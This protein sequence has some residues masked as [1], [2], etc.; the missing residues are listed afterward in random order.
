MSTTLHT[1]MDIFKEE[2]ESDGKW[3]QVQKIIIPI[4][5]RDYA[6][7][8]RT[9]K[10]DRIRSRFLDSLYDAVTKEAVILDFVYGSIDDNGVM[11]PLDGQQRLTTLFLLHWYAAVKENVAQQEYSFLKNFSYETSYSARTFCEELM[12]YRYQGQSLLSEEIIDQAWFPL[13]WKKDPTISSMLVMLDAMDDR[14]KEVDNLWEKLKSGA[15]SFYFLPIADLGLTDELYIKMNSRGKLLTQFEHFKAELE[16]TLRIVDGTK[17]REVMHKVDIAWTDMLW[18]YRGDNNIIDDEF[19][20]YFKFICDIIC[21][22]NGGTV[23]GRS[24]DEFF[25]LKE[26]FSVEAENALQNIEILQQYFDCWCDLK[27]TQRISQFFESLFS[28]THEADKIQ[29]R[30][31]LDLFADCLNHYGENNGRNR[32]FPLNRVVLLYAVV[33]YL[34]KKEEITKEQF[35]RRFRIINNLVRNSEDEVSDSEQ[36]SSGNRMPAILKQVEDILVRER[37]DASVVGFS[38]VQ[39]EEEIKKL[40]W[41][42]QY[43]EKAL[44]L[45]RLEDHYLL[46]GQIG[47][48]GLKNETGFEKFERLFEC[49]LD[50]VDSALMATGAYLQRERNGWRYQC[51]TS[52]KKIQRAWQDLFHHGANTGYPETKKV[53]NRL[54]SFLTEISDAALQAVV[55][56]YIQEC[57][58]LKTYNWRYYYVKYKVFRPGSYGKYYWADYEKQPYVI[59]VMQTGKNISEYSYQ[60]FLKAV[61]QYDMISKD[62]YGAYLIDGDTYIGVEQ[63]AYVIY[64]MEDD[65]EIN[66]ISILQNENGVDMENRIVRLQQY[67]EGQEQQKKSL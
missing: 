37:L 22:K 57:E 67:M 4:I 11:T 23:Q 53:L 38:S 26:Y 54:L 36:R 35:L 60:P 47:I 33:V 3:I 16:R 43:P 40:A 14:F 21:Y 44:K 25:L 39:M 9:D 2:I 58:A 20:R 5:Q 46:Y 28:N 34:L 1:F 55:D 15:I 51:G 64:S 18:E 56:G 8:R 41:V 31:E 42:R 24:Q 7:G 32:R 29:I 27:R 61:D 13:D 63:D 49:D 66:R 10:I 17:A 62:D 30:G 65:R 19:L 59:R 52:N 50:L 45:Y 48:I 6:Q 12:H